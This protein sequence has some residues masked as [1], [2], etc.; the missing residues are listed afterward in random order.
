VAEAVVAEAAEKVDK[1]EE[2]MEMLGNQS[3]N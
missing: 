1:E 3:P 2:E